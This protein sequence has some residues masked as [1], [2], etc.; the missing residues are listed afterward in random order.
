MVCQVKS[1]VLKLTF[2]M[3]TDKNWIKCQLIAQFPI[4]QVP[5]KFAY[6][7]IIPFWVS[8]ESSLR[9][10]KALPFKTFVANIFE[11][12]AVTFLHF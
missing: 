10:K 9:G 2:C 6:V 5:Q 7:V 12:F 8:S 1:A 11:N 3:S 4:C